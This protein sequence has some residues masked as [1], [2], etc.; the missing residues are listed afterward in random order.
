MGL[1]GPWDIYPV[2]VL[3]KLQ[4]LH[5]IQYFV[6][7]KCMFCCLFKFCVCDMLE[8][9]LNCLKLTGWQKSI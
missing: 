7:I 9:Y 3:D 4:I 2:P 1:Y 8:T 5:N 6:L